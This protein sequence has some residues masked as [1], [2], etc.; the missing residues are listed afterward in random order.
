MRTAVIGAGGWGTA[1]AQHLGLKGF[2]VRL[3]SHDPEKARQMAE[4]RENRAYLPGIRLVDSISVT[5]HLAEALEGAE[6]VLEVVPSHAVRAVMGEAAPLLHPGVPIVTC[7]KG[8]ENETLLTMLE[9]LEDVL[10]VTLHPYLAVLSGPS[11][12]RELAQQFPTAVS[13]A[14]RWERI[15]QE[16]Q[17]AL[18]SSALKVYTSVDVVGVELGGAVKNVIALG[19]GIAE[20]LGYG[21]NTRAA[22]ITRGLVEISR[23]AS[24]K[25]ANPLTVSGLSGMGDLVLTCTGELSRNRWVG[26]ELGRGRALEEV[27][28][29]MEMVAEGVKNARSVHHLAQKLQV[30]VPICESVYRVLY[31]GL[32]PQEAVAQLMGRAPAAEFH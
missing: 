12:A 22:I 15:A 23:L 1:L 13:V 10:P 27:L 21:H 6:L 24:R 31:E 18:T 25:G 20:G 16:V 32:S 30:E 28:G 14:A 4:L 11:F 19:A 29:E 3:W 17:T 2:P 7:S 9:V 5:P 26:L 8:I